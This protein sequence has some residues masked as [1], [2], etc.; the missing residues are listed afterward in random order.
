MADTGKFDRLFSRNEFRELAGPRH[1][2]TLLLA[3]LLTLTFCALGFALGGYQALKTNMENPFT[4]WVDIHL[5]GF[6]RAKGDKLQEF[7][8]QPTVQQQFNLQEVIY[9]QRYFYPFRSRAHDPLQHGGQEFAWSF[10]GRT[11]ES[12][13][14]LMEILNEENLRFI[15]KDLLEDGVPTLDYCGLIVTAKMMEKLGYEPADYA[16]VQYLS[17]GDEQ[18]QIFLPLYAVVRALP[19]RVDFA[20]FPHAYNILQGE[21]TKLI[22]RNADNLADRDTFNNV[23]IFL[24]SSAANQI[25]SLKAKL[26]DHFQQP[27]DGF[28]IQENH[29]QVDA[30][31][32]YSEYDVSFPST[33]ESA[34]AREWLEQLKQLGKYTDYTHIDCSEEAGDLSSS[35][36]QTLAF[37][38]M[39]KVNELTAFQ[40]ELEAATQLTIPMEDV[41]NR[42][43]FA[44]ITRLT[45]ILSSTLFLFSLLSIVLYLVNLLNNHVDKLRP[46]LGTFKAMGL[47]NG[48]L[49][50]VYIKI[51][52]R[53]LLTATVLALP[54][55]WGIGKL[56]DGSFL[57]IGFNLWHYTVPLA[58]LVI[59]VVVALLVRQRLV[60]IFNITPG[61]LIYERS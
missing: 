53:F 17:T 52:L 48:Q 4:R 38:D 51:A 60:K 7:L 27:G 36:H 37:G 61:N 33:I 59:L 35:D 39:L 30:E 25:S 2:V 46:H 20:A 8:E 32:S 1:Q 21:N 55:A 29:Y 44:V 31:K 56:A 11:L 45:A 28:V 47:P 23:R 24:L 12:D 16:S 26:V 40:E 6:D 15:N 19:S 5:G 42:K 57:Q 14:L 50:R 10:P 54:L 43:N 3:G 18:D 13:D 22:Q 9:W 34:A 41:E 58:L 49:L